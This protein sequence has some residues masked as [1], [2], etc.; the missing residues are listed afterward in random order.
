MAKPFRFTASRAPIIQSEIQPVRITGGPGARLNIDFGQAMFGT[1]A[2]SANAPSPTRI[3]VHLGEILNAQG[4]VDRAPEGTIRYRA[5][6]M[7]LSAGLHHYRAT[8]P[9]DERST[10]P[11]F[12]ILMPPEIGEVLPFRYAEIEHHD[13]A[14]VPASIRMIAAHVPFDDTASH[15]HSS[16]DTLNAVWALCRH[17]IKAT[18]FLGIYVDGDRE[19]IPYEGDAYINQ[20]CHYCM[21]AGVSYQMARHTL[22]Y[23]IQRPTWFTD[24]LLHTVLMAWADYQYTGQLDT[25]HAFYDDLKLHL[26][27]PCYSQMKLYNDLVDWPPG[28]FTQGGIG[29]R[30]N[31]EMLPINSVVNAIH[32]GTLLCMAELAKAAGNTQNHQRFAAQAALLYDTFNRVFFDEKQGVYIDGE[33]SSHASLHSNMF[34]LAMGLVP[35]SRRN[36]VLAFVQSRGMA[37]SVYGAQ[38]LLDGLYNMGAADYALSLMT[39]RHDR[40]WY[41]MIEQGSTVTLEAWAHRYKNNLDW[42]HAWGAAPGNII[43][44]RLMGVQPLQPGFASL[45]IAP[46]PASL[47]YA[48]LRTPT[49]RGSVELLWEKQDS[50]AQLT[51]TTPD[52]MPVQLD[53]SGIGE[54]EVTLNGKRVE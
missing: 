50:S 53:R 2:F 33:G 52:N 20:L 10:R 40:S 1:L 15:F 8:V 14:I 39:A 41:H 12:A 32:Y 5:I 7:D 31:H 16:D 49:P 21:D 35:R 46:Q 22:E 19:R 3:T 34:P 26:A 37:C 24:W 38:H 27:D 11:P 42:N 25:L 23:L 17:S 36:S 43:P 54:A 9:P 29:E 48:F 6:E 13:A 45:L 4:R 44:R 51:I 30:D 18:S 47:T 28:S